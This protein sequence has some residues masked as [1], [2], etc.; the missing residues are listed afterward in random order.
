MDKFLVN[1]VNKLA[2][3]E[4]RTGPVYLI[5]PKPLIAVAKQ[6][7]GDTPSVKIVEQREISSK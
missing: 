4:E 3:Q 5:L 2:E 7:F 6:M 1:F